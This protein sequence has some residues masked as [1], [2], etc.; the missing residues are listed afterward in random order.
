MQDPPGRSALHQFQGF[1]QV[2]LKR[3]PHRRGVFQDLLLLSNKLIDLH[4]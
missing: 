1:A 3:I 4:C 2:L